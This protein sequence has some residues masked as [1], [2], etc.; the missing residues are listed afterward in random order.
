M[1]KFE[2][3]EIHA[4]CSFLTQLCP[5]FRLLTDEMISNWL[6]SVP[7]RKLTKPQEGD[8]NLY[9]NNRE[10][11][12]FTLLICGKLEVLA[13]EDQFR[14]DCPT[15]TF[16]AQDCLTS[17]IWFS[18]CT[19]RVNEPSYIIQL[20]RQTFLEMLGD[21]IEDWFVPP[22]ELAWAKDFLEDRRLAKIEN[23]KIRKNKKTAA[24]VA[25]FDSDAFPT[26]SPTLVKFERDR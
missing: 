24:T 15:W 7:I 10:S 9:Y 2:E 17:K 5:P 11:D 22:P 21:C 3:R 12:T 14:I 20:T 8:L 16:I 25:P 18:D 4:I 26:P 23:D 19:I 6:R 1:E 13:G